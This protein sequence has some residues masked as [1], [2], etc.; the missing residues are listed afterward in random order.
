[1]SNTMIVNSLLDPGLLMKPPP[2]MLLPYEMLTYYPLLP[3]PDT[4]HPEKHDL[5]VKKLGQCSFVFD[6]MDAVSD[7]KGKEI[8]RASL[9]ELVDY[10]TTERGVL[11]EEIYPEVI[12]MVR[13]LEFFESVCSDNL[14]PLTVS[15]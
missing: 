8:K 2:A 7:L 5:V 14:S 15:S 1:M 11:Q 12:H 9:N 10:I 13:C 6:F 3:S 4:P